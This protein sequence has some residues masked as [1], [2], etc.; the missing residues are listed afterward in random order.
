MGKETIW[1]CLLSPF[2]NLRKLL[3]CIIIPQC[4]FQHPSEA[5]RYVFR[6]W[7]WSPWSVQLSLI[8]AIIKPFCYK[9]NTLKIIFFIYCTCQG[10]APATFNDAGNPITANT[11]TPLQK[12]CRL[13]TRTCWSFSRKLLSPPLHIK[14][15]IFCRK[16]LSFWTKFR[17]SLEQK[18]D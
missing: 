18:S 3:P 1:C 9:P 4:C 7:C 15:W 11:N 17:Q 14:I 10:R 5:A 2:Q 8:A 16:T 13:T 6:S 12:G